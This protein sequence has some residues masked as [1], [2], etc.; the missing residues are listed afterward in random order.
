MSRLSYLSPIHYSTVMQQYLLLA[1]EVCVTCFE[2][3]FQLRQL[4]EAWEC[5]FFVMTS[6]I[7]GKVEP[8]RLQRV[9]V[10]Q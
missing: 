8:R 9:I 1:S 10:K 5:P 4:V 7:G 2:S 6:F 3:V